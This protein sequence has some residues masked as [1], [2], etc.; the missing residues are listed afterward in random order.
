MS[1]EV[2]IFGKLEFPAGTLSQWMDAPVDPGTF[3]DTPLPFHVDEQED[4]PPSVDSRLHWY[5]STRV[6][7]EGDRLELR[8]RLEKSMFWDIVRHIVAAFRLAAGHGGRGELLLIGSAGAE[9]LGFRVEVGDGRSVVRRLPIE[10]TFAIHE[11]PPIQA[12]E[13]EASERLRTAPDAD[14]KAGAATAKRSPFGDL[15]A[16]T[17]H[18]SR[19]AHRRRRRR[20]RGPQPRRRRIHDRPRPSPRH[21]AERHQAALRRTGTNVLFQAGDCQ[22]RATSTA[23]GCHRLTPSSTR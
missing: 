8:D 17:E 10:E 1:Y 19:G 3:P 14:D 4:D 12:I 11:S 13:D 16:S 22:R 9:D 23:C 6:D 20:R 18:P 21:T 2:I 7:V 15:V 5:S